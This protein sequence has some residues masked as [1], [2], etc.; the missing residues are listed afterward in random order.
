VSTPLKGVPITA[1]VSPT[2]DFAQAAG[3]ETVTCS[4]LEGGYEFAFGCDHAE[5]WTSVETNSLK[6]E[7]RAQGQDPA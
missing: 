5:T 2:K 6:Q 1:F 7:R 3:A 4:P